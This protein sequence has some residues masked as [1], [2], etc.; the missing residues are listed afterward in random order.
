MVRRELALEQVVRFANYAGFPDKHRAGDRDELIAAFEDSAHDDDHVK[1]I[2]DWLMRHRPVEV[3]RFCP[4]P[5]EVYAASQATMPSDLAYSAVPE[6]IGPRPG[7]EPFS[8]LPDLIDDKLRNR[9][10]ELSLTR[11]LAAGKRVM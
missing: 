5:A 10:K 3:C 4:L 7:D 11:T 6:S 2:G 1:R 8:G 9:I